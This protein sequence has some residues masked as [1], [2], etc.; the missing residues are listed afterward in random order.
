MTF[1]CQYRWYQKQELSVKY[2][3]NDRFY[4]YNKIT[5]FYEINLSSEEKKNVL[6]PNIKKTIVILITNKCFKLS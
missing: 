5:I 1:S 2:V 6:Q 4:W 3:F